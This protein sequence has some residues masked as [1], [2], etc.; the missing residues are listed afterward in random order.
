MTKTVALLYH[1]TPLRCS[2][3]RTPTS[4]GFIYDPNTHV[5]TFT[6]TLAHAH[7][8]TNAHTRTR[9]HAHTHTRAHAH[10]HTQVRNPPST[11]RTLITSISFCSCRLPTPEHQIPSHQT[12]RRKL[13]AL[14]TEMHTH[15]Y[16]ANKHT[17]TNAWMR[18][19]TNAR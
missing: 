18:R 16:S 2:A 12:P 1:A 8:R 19:R 11:L 13:A 14:S 17:R 5:D 9:A 15:T 4:Q 7:T 3:P 6:R 10:T